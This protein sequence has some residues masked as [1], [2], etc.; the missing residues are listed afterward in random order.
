MNLD[1]FIET[2]PKLNELNELIFFGGSFNPWH[3]GHSS[4]IQLMDSTKSI[5]IVP[6]HNPYK[7]L[8]QSTKKH[9]SLDQIEAKLKEFNNDTFLF[10]GFF[11]QDQK[12]PTHQWIVN[13]KE[14]FPNKKL[15]LLMGFDTFMGLDKWINAQSLLDNLTHIYVASREDDEQLKSKQLQLLNSISQINIVFLGHHDYEDLS[16]SKIRECK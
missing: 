11:E 9:S 16:S 8:V 12:N 2:T 7:E 10:A 4:C 3:E 6:D 14:K 13:L 5:I 1:H 15:S